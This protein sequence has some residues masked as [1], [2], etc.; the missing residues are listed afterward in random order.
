MASFRDE[1]R[2]VLAVEGL[3]QYLSA[4]RQ[5]QQGN[6]QA[7]LQV[8]QLH[9]NLRGIARPLIQVGEALGIQAGQWAVLAAAMYGARTILRQI[10]ETVH[11][12]MQAFEKYNTVLFRT[13]FLFATMGGSPGTNALRGFARERAAATG[14]AE[15]ETLFLLGRARQSG[16]G[17][18]TAGRL[19]PLLQDVQA[20]GLTSAQNALDIINRLIRQEGRGRGSLG[21][22]SEAATQL[23]LDPRFFTGGQQHDLQEVMRQLTAKVG[24]LSNQ[25]ASTV[26]GTFSRNQELLNGTMRRLG[27]II[28]ASL[29]PIIEVLNRELLGLNRAFDFVTGGRGIENP[30]VATALGGALGGAVLELGPLAFILQGILQLQLEGQIDNAR[31]QDQ[32][33][34]YLQDIAGNTQNMATALFASVFGSAS[35]FTRQGIAYRNLQAAIGPV[36]TRGA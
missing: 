21:A 1:L 19:V 10:Q 32:A 28:E 27:A 36:P 33:N 5:A 2:T 16:F 22:V 12:A 26:S 6:L 8:Q 29:V 24:G 7:A 11:E 15:D 18:Q 25:L 4:L 35:A 30:R 9:D 13:S 23:R 20:S 3:S 34:K 14:I 31:K 17:P